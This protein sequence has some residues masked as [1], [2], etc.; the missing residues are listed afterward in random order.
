[1]DT[2]CFGFKEQQKINYELLNGMSS[3]SSLLHYN[4]N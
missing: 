1:M 3:F 2:S 4:F